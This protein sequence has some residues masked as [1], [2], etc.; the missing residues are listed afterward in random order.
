M[1]NKLLIC[2][3]LI[4]NVTGVCLP[5]THL[6]L[7]GKKYLLNAIKHVKNYLSSM[8][9]KFSYYLVKV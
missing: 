2:K 7:S 6:S 5:K 8:D 1:I 9:T 3:P 4:T